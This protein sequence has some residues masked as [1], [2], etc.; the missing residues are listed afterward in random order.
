MSDCFQNLGQA[1]KKGTYRS[2]I[3][4][5]SFSILAV[6]WLRSTTNGDEMEVRCWLTERS[7]S[8]FWLAA[9]SAAGC[10]GHVIFV[11]G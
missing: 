7:L 9:N 1:W 6:V 11:E 5:F 2:T 8:N 3:S 10:V 4:P